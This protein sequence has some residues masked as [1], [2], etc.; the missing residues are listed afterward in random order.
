MPYDGLNGFK[1]SP[2]N[3]EDSHFVFT[4][5][6]AFLVTQSSAETGFICVAVTL[7]LPIE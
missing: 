4:N 7:I 6:M 1:K 3:D 5:C 2:L